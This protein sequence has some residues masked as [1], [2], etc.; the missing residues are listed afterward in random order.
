[1]EKHQSEILKQFKLNGNAVSCEPYGTGHINDTYLVVTDAG[2][3]YI[4]QRL[5]TNV[6]KDPMVVMNNIEKVTAHLG[7]KCSDPREVLHLVYT[8]DDKC[9]LQDETG[10]YRVYDFVEDSVCVLRPTKSD[11][12]QC[13]VAFGK[14]QY[15]LSDFPAE[16]LVETIPDFHNTPKRFKDFEKAVEEDVVGRVA[17][18]QEEIAFIKEREAFTHVLMDAHKEGRLPLRVSHNDTKSDNV[19]LDAETHAALCVIDLDTIM[20]GFAVTDFGDSI[21]FGASTALED[22]P[23]LDKVHL[24]MELYNTYIKGFLAG[25]KHSMEPGEID[26]L[27]EGAKMMTLECGMRFLAD[28]LQGDVYFKTAYP[29]HNLVRARTQIKLVKEMEE[30]W[31]EMKEAAHN[32]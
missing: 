9:Y 13:A 12:E 17:T 21:R 20:P 14:F 32:A 22:E 26:L 2:V 3:R 5:N 31:D 19:M 18:A 6:F 24:D 1:M 15:D 10:F 23:D 28:Y 16:E 11:F 27:A 7:K 4:L 8:T 25:N 29:E 30:H